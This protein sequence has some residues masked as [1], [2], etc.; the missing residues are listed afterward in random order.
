[1]EIG[2]SKLFFHFPNIALHCNPYILVENWSKLEDEARRIWIFAARSLKI[3]K[4][5]EKLVGKINGKVMRVF[6]FLNH[7]HK[8]FISLTFIRLQS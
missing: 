7:F 5:T 8:N 1:M 2:P 6:F 3:F 4:Q